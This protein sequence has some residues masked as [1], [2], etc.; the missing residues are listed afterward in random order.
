MEINARVYVIADSPE[1]LKVACDVLEK[2][3]EH[4]YFGVEMLEP[5][6]VLPLSRPW[7]GFSVS[8]GPTSG[9]EYGDG[10]WDDGLRKCAGL[11]KKNGAVVVE[12]WS[13]DYPDEDCTY[14]HT[15][16]QGG[17]E[18][19]GRCSLYSYKRALGC[20]DVKMVYQELASGR[21]RRQRDAAASRMEKQARLRRE[22]G[23]FEVV[24]GILKKY[25]GTDEHVVIPEGVKEIGDF[26]FVDECGWER[27]LLEDEAYDAPALEALEIP[28]G[29]CR[30][31]TYALAYCR[32]LKKLSI[33]D[34]VT[35]IGER[36]FE[37]C[38][39]LER[40]RLPAGLKAIEDSTFFLCYGLRTVVFPESLEE[41][42]PN[43]FKGCDSLSRI[44]LPQGLQR[45]G[46][47]AF[48]DCGKLR[49]INL[50]S[51][52]GSSDMRSQEGSV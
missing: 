46:K 15:T 36:A 50:P 40:A 5:N 29:V 34:S 13:P 42:G 9:P 45:I 2:Q 47:D 10:W 25:R 17:V 6:A 41:I 31:G 39:A 12:F 7:Y 51:E 21:T 11:L 23:D 38:E 43:A 33:P 16:P 49:D 24:N 27:M 28:D 1:L 22:K 19:G 20:D 18:M 44:A 4:R 52:N 26:A 8:T 35:E 32:N 3:M 37:G 14:A 48:K 30:I